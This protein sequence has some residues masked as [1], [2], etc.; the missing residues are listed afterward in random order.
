MPPSLP[1]G[2]FVFAVRADQRRA[3]ILGDESF[4]FPP[5]EALVTEDDLSFPDELVVVLKERL[6]GFTCTVFGFAWPQRTGMPAGVL[7]R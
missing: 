5:G 1:K 6:G 3:L 7:I 2:V 4:E